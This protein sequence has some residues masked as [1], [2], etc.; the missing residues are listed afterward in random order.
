MDAVFYR[1]SQI[2][3][4]CSMGNV[5]TEDDSGIVGPGLFPHPFSQPDL[6]GRPEA[7]PAGHNLLAL[8]SPL[9]ALSSHF[10]RKA[11]LLAGEK[12]KQHHVFSWSFLFEVI[13]VLKGRKQKLCRPPW[14]SWTVLAHPS[15]IH[16]W[17]KPHRDCYGTSAQMFCESLC[18]HSH[19]H[20]VMTEC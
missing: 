10:H 16:N 6:P 3:V 15:L 8:L 1:S 18:C 7:A 12:R 14:S 13:Y 17:Y 20:I 19:Y 5:E 2:L 4:A 11:A 9:R